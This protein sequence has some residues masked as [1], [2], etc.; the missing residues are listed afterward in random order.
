MNFNKITYSNSQLKSKYKEYVNAEYY[1]TKEIK[2]KFSALADEEHF[3]DIW[4][5]RERKDLSYVA[6]SKKLST[7][8]GVVRRVVR[9]LEREESI[10]KDIL[11]G[12]KITGKSDSHQ[13]TDLGRESLDKRAELKKTFYKDTRPSGS[14]IKLTN[15][16][17]LYFIDNVESKSFA[18]ISKDI[19]KDE[20]SL[21]ADNESDSGLIKERLKNLNDRLQ[22]KCKEDGEI[23]IDPNISIRVNEAIKKGL[24]KYSDGSKFTTLYKY[25]ELSG[26]EKERAMA[27]KIAEDTWLPKAREL[28]KKGMSSRKMESKLR[29]LGFTVGK[30]TILKYIKDKLI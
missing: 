1:G 18:D 29:A 9:F 8:E 4:S 27:L 28:N 7:S 10:I 3:I 12:K 21:D 19:I 20:G 17:I 16:Q 22:G 13:G 25:K 23:V 14:R 24:I 11:A 6:I 15:D 26:P 30:T 5:L 2:D